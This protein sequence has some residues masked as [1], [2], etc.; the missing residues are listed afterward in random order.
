M[1][2]LFKK[3]IFGS[4]NDKEIKKIE[5]ILTAVN[6]H[7]QAVSALSDKELRLKTGTF[8]EHLRAKEQSLEGSITRLRRQIDESTTQAARDKE[9]VKLKNLYNSLFD[10]ILPEAFAV[11]RE[12]AKR[13]INMRHFDCQIIGGYVLHQGRIAEMATGEGKTLVATLP[14]YLNALLG[15]GV[16]VVTVNDYLSKRD[17]EWM[18]PV[19]EFLGLSIGVI[20]HDMPPEARTLSYNSDITYGTNNEFGFDYLRDNMVISKQDMVQREP[21]FAIVDEVDSILIDE[22]RT[23][24]IISG[25]AEMSTDKYYRIDKIIPKLKKGARDEKT[26]EETGDYIIDEKARTAYLTEAGEIKVTELLGIPDMHTT[27]TQEYKKHVEQ[28]LRAHA[29]FKL[30]VD[31]IVKDGQ[32]IIVDEFTGRL[33]PGR[34]WSDGLHQA[35]EAKE[36]V[37]IERENQTLATI[38]F[39][40]YFR[41][42]DKLAGMTGT[43]LTESEEFSK[44]YNLDVVSIPTNKP[45][46]RTNHPDIVY[47]TVKEKF[48]AIV[49]EIEELHKQG[50]PVL[51]GTVSID[52]S[53][54]IGQLLERKGVPHNVLNAKYHEFEAHIVAQ[55]GSKGAVTIATN[56]AGRGTDILLGGNPEF[57]AEDTITKM[58]ASGKD[59]SGEERENALSQYRQET[60]KEHE[61]VIRAGGL[62]VIG[63]ER[64]EARRIDNQ[65]RGRSGRQGDPGSSRFYVSLED[66]LMRIFASDRVTRLINFFGLEEGTPIAE[67]KIVARSI[68]TAQRRVESHNFEIRKHVLEY[69]NV[70]NKQRE[71]I[72]AERKTILESSNLRE[73]IFNMLED[74]VDSGLNLYAPEN[75][76]PEEWD[77]SNLLSWLRGKFL[78]KLDD[79]K[80]T[81]LSREELG[82]YILQEIKTAYEQK[83]AAIT[84]EKMQE[85]AKFVMLQAIDGKWKDHLLSID[86]L[87]EG[88]HLRGYG[89]RDPLV[90]Y[91]REAYDMFM[92]M[93][94]SIRDDSLEYIFRIQA[95]ET[96]KPAGV[97]RSMPHQLVHENPGSIRDIKPP[98][99]A[100]DNMDLS[101]TNANYRTSQQGPAQPYKRDESKVGRNDPCP[102]GSN[103]KYKKCCG[104]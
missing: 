69:D 37:K 50:R 65:L 17:R 51:V 2:G 85:I 5:H 19:Y 16:H 29:N 101:R 7:E 99:P 59:V 79:E 53:E 43:A 45:L 82:D 68:E 60:E 3:I 83:E 27:E 21:F 6:S 55:A 40:N 47:R 96:Q 18:G 93:I 20:Q 33:M 22:A 56:M 86:H 92:S 8:R 97:F 63:S 91:Q 87:R 64:H 12:A 76:H 70:M 57:R 84:P 49:E 35:I 88:I 67:H 61:E 10:E 73:H 26:K 30:D 23:P 100:P 48:N 72:Y 28:A 103:K 9:K 89:Q 31:Y 32:V 95:I 42:Y 80:I 13:T 77:Y 36:G 94:D 54:Y 44:I 25:P 98:A 4:H 74:I 104:K 66:D 102:C 58:A 75:L 52:K 15:K 41:M 46:A 71:I 90:E 14:V 34:R 81:P 1:I 38:T 24:L 11:V 39:Q 62:H 78:I